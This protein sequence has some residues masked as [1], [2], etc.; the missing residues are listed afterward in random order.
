MHI[1]NHPKDNI[2]KKLNN[3]Y[4][5]KTSRQ[6]AS[7]AIL[8]ISSTTVSAG[9]VPVDWKTPG[10]NLLVQDTS[11][12]IEWLKLTETNGLNYNDVSAQLGA[13]G[14]YEGLRYATS[15]EVVNLYAANFFIDLSEGATDTITGP[16]DSRIQ[17]VANALGN[18]VNQ[19]NLQIYPFGVLGFTA[20]VFTGIQ[21]PTQPPKPPAPQPAHERLGA[22][23][24]SPNMDLTTGDNVYNTANEYYNWD[25]NSNVA[26]GHYLVSAVPLPSAVWLFGSGV[27]GLF[28]VTMRKQR[29]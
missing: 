6:L 29:T 16:F 10:D 19:L 17:D 1:C 3:S 24:Y 12:G 21:K 11:S 27:I 5:Y 22:Y 18:I 9:L 15:A 26:W 7:A 28:G 13:G 23:Y 4:L 8:A 14:T 2:V 20:D 25:V